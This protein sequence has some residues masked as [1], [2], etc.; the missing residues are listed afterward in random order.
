MFDLL[1]SLLHLLLNFQYIYKGWFFLFSRR[2]R[3]SYY[4]EH[5]NAETSFFIMD[6]GKMFAFI[7]I[8]LLLISFFI[9]WL[10]DAEMFTQE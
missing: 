8:E 5:Q 1:G 3:A 4:K 6:F 9:L 7:V 10:L 2:Y